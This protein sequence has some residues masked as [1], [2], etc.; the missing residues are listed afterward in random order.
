MSALWLAVQSRRPIP[1]Y[2]SAHRRSFR[3]SVVLWRY[4]GRPELQT[5]TRGL[6]ALEGNEGAEL[7]RQRWVKRFK[8]VWLGDVEARGRRGGHVY[9][10]RQRGYALLSFAKIQNGSK[11]ALPIWVSDPLSSEL[12]GL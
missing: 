1:R 8:D 4:G 3:L 7:R 10:L 2:I 11:K 12:P 5:Y 9:K 6:A